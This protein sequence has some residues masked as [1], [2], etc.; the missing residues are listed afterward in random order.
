M[1]FLILFLFIDNIKVSP[2]SIDEVLSDHDEC[3]LHKESLDLVFELREVPLLVGLLLEEL[4]GGPLDRLALPINDL[5][6]DRPSGLSDDVEGS[7]SD[8]CLLLSLRLT[9]GDRLRLLLFELLL[10]VLIFKVVFEGGLVLR[11]R[12]G[13]N[14]GSL[15]LGLLCW[16]TARIP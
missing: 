16:R 8:E 10:H 5:L 13:N 11:T 2:H 1:M 9:A 15:L 12:G 6:V 3:L 4:P 14:L 7:L